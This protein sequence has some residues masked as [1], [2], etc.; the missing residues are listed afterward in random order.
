MSTYTV[1]RQQPDQYDFTNPANPVAGTLVIFQ[2][3]EGNEGTVFV[4]ATR[5][6]VKNVRT[7]VAAKAKLIDEIGAL[8]G[9][10]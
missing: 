3:S 1:I 2:T 4:P 9:S 7:M 8:E 6:T 5:Y 10:Y